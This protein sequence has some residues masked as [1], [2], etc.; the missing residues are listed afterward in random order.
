[1]APINLFFACILTVALLPQLK[2]WA[3]SGNDCHRLVPLQITSVVTPCVYP[4]LL[5]SPNNEN[6]GIVLRR[7][8]DGTPC[9]ITRNSS[10][11]L[12][13]Q[14]FKCINGLCQFLNLELQLKRSKRETRLIRKRRGLFKKAKDKIKKRR[15]RRKK[16][17]ANKKAEKKKKNIE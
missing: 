12:Q 5:I 2:A 3:L 13:F 7:E 1:M 11:S 10:P 6:S 9:K 17:K 16:K 14:E 15:Q 8:V 4:C